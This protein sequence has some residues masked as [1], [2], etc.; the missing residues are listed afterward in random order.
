MLHPSLTRRSKWFSSVK[1]IEKGDV[2]IIVDE[3]SPTNCW[4]KG[5][6][7]ETV[8]GKNGQVRQA[9][10][11]ISSGVLTRPAVKLAV[12]DVLAKEV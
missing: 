9:V 1:P 6:V 8:V 12:L 4:P 7:V 2:V 5:L 11:Q 10:V 3:N